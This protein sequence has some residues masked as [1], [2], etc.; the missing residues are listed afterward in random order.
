[1]GG[2]VAWMQFISVQA[3]SVV[4]RPKDLHGFSS[5]HFAHSWRNTLGAPNGYQDRE[6]ASPILMSPLAMFTTSLM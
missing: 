3:L 6:P 1:M 4:C 2:L 5:G